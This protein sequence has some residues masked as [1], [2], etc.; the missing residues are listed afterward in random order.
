MTHRLTGPDIEL[1][2]LTMA[3]RSL[4]CGLYGDSE[5]MR[6][7]AAPVSAEAAERAFDR[8]LAGL[9]RSWPTTLLWTIRPSL[10]PA[11]VGLL[12]LVATESDEAELGV[13]LE[14]SA[15]GRGIAARAILLALPFA[16]N[17]LG[18][19]RVTTRHDPHN[20]PAQRLMEA[21]RFE[22]LP[23]TDDHRRWQCMQGGLRHR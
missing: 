22:P 12:G 2:P 19:R 15:S 10:G 14:P 4:Y 8:V 16:F 1:V 11:P 23:I 5:V 20:R 7:V 13:L 21:V 3:D 6:W 18:L 17:R 9:S